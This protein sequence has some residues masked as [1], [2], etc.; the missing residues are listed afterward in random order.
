MCKSFVLPF[1]DFQQGPPE[2]NKMEG[3]EKDDS[4]LTPTCAQGKHGPCLVQTAT[5]IPLFTSDLGIRWSKLCGHH[6]LAYT[7][8][9]F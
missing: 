3:D 1:T 8:S 2:T 6:G 9:K 7:A 5:V 4:L